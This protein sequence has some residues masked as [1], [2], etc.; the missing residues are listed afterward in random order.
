MNR[1]GLSF[2]S[3]QELGET[4]MS[5]QSNRRNFLKIGAGSAGAFVFSSSISKAFASACGLTPPQTPGPFYPGKEEFH[6]DNDLTRLSGHLSRAKGQV[7]YIKG[8]IVDTKCNPIQGATVEIWQACESGKYNNPN[9]PNTAP[10]DPDFKYWG[11]TYS[12]Q[13]GEYVF[14]TIIPGAYPADTDWIRPPHIHFK[15]SR[16]GYQ[17]LVTQMYFKGNSYN[18]QD[19]I[20]RRIPSGERNSVIVSFEP[21]PA[22]YDAR[23]LL[24]KFD[25][26]LRSVR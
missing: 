9:D 22:E 11:E 1:S 16:L 17:E 26:T 6:Q 23:S 20:L 19:L 7:V 14:K 25:I 13:N 24:G 12:D 10:L 21:S 5:S 18:D 4:F 8:K 3:D 15:V 2:L